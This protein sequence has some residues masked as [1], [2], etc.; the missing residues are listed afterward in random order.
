MACYILAAGSMLVGLA[1]YT[2]R[3][4]VCFENVSMVD[5]EHSG[6]WVQLS[7]IVTHNWHTQPRTAP[8]EIE[9]AC[10]GANREVIELE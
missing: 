7:E 5:G 3:D 8:E 2:H 4:Y 1:K 6:D 10:Q 9:V